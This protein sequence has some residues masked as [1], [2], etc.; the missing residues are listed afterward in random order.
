MCVCVCVCV[1]ACVCVCGVCVLCVT[2]VCTGIN[3]SQKFKNVVC[4]LIQHLASIGV[5]VKIVPRDHDLHFEGQNFQ[6]LIS[7]KQS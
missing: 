3:E 1:R 2:I 4:T 6:L 5:I 7:V